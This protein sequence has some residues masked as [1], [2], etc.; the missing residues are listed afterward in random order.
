MYLKHKSLVRFAHPPEAEN[1]G[2]L[3][4]WNNGKLH[5]ITLK[6]SVIHGINYHSHRKYK[7]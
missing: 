2:M 3:E 5:S 7:L 1:D 4:Y 6:N